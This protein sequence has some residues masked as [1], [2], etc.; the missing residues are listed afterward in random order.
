MDERVRKP[1]RHRFGA[2]GQVFGLLLGRAL[3]RVCQLGQVHR[4]AGIAVEDHVFDS[5]AQLRLNLFVDRQRAGV[6][7]PHV[8]AGFDGVI[9]ERAVH[10]LTYGVVA[11]IGERQI[12]DAAAHQT[13]R[14]L[15][16]DDP[17]C[18]DIGDRVVV[19]LVHASSHREDV[20]VEDDVLG[21]KLF[22]F[23]ENPVGPPADGDLAVARVG[24][25]VL[26]HGHDDRG[27]AVASHQARFFAESFL[28]VLE[29]DGV[30]DPLALQAFQAGLDDLPV[31]AVDHDRHPG[32]LRI[33][34]RQIQ[35]PGHCLRAI[36]QRVIHVHVD[37]LRAVADLMPRHV[38]GVL[39]L[40]LFDQA[41]ELPRASHVGPLTDIHEQ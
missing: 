1:R 14:Q 28:A 31:G 30:D 18:I 2:P 7:D 40:L 34:R 6:D 22:L 11:A 33:R 13:M 5:P 26:V 21:R 38:E 27:R 35:E 19:V 23:G 32:N 41:G 29:A 37:H 3:D 25:A 15:L 12:A 36:Q 10:R 16:L 24:L 20:R 9:Q 39:V 4:G 8:H 17:A